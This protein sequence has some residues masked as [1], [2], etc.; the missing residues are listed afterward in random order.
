MSLFSA[1]AKLFSPTLV[2]PLPSVLLT[3]SRWQYLSHTPIS[4]VCFAV[5]VTPFLKRSNSLLYLLLV[6]ACILW[7]WLQD[8]SPWIP[9][10]EDLVQI[11]GRGWEAWHITLIFCVA[12]K[13][14]YGDFDDRC[15]VSTD[16]SE[17]VMR[18][19]CK[20][21]KSLLSKSRRSKSISCAICG[22]EV[23]LV[24]DS[25]SDVCRHCDLRWF[26]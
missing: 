26:L 2:T 3:S 6:S 7:N 17:E 14:I 4:S 13:G 16:W 24:F 1:T 9:M 11:A 22:H 12:C 19:Y 21:R 10:P 5:E 23:L 15:G 25:S 18:R 20:Q 8:P